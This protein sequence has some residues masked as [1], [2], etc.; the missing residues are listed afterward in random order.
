[1][2]LILVRH[3]QP[4]WSTP[5]GL[6]RNDPG[7]T[8]LGHAQARLIADRIAD[9]ADEPALEGAVDHLLASPALRA[10]Q[11]AAPIADALGQ[12][13]ETLDWLLEIQLPADWEGRPIEDIQRDYQAMKDLSR[14]ELWTGIAGG[15]APVDFHRR[16]T[17]GLRGLLAEH[18]IEPATEHG[19]WD[20][21]ADGADQRLVAVAHGG[22]NSMIIAHL[23]NVEPEPWEWDRF[24]MGHASVAVLRTIPMAGAHLWSL[25]ALG[26]AAHLPLDTRTR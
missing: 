24:A 7:L 16:I 11:T 12:D 13:A 14:D 18:G 15:E 5:E 3:G 9:R 26:D 2:E 6:G 8:D 23:L 17:G 19:L 20:V 1:M 21:P 10:Q 4:A 22:T 25:Q